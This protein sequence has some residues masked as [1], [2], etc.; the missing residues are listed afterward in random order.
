MSLIAQPDAGALRVL[1]TLRGAGHESYLCGG[2]VRDAL[3][4]RQPNDWDIATD[5]PPERVEALFPRTVAV[6][7]AFGVVVVVEEDVNYQ[8]ASFRADGKYVDGRRPETVRYSSAKEDAERRDFTINA[9]FYDPETDRV[10][11]Y[12]GGQEDLK[13]RVLRT[14]GD[15][16]RRFQEDHLRLL[17][18]V[19]FAAST[20]FDL[21]PATRDAVTE[22]ADR[23][24][25]V[26]AERIGAEITRMLVEGNARRSIELLVETGLS[27]VTLPEID[28]LAGV[29]QPE[30]FHPEGDVWVHTCIMLG[31]LDQAFRGGRV[32][33]GPGTEDYR[34]E[35]MAYAVLLHDIGKPETFTVSDRIRFN[36]HDTLG[37]AMGER[38]LERLKRP[39]RVIE[40]VENLIR[41]HMHFAALPHMRTAKRRRFLQEDLFELHLELHRIDC[42]GSHS[43]LTTY[44]FARQAL[45]EERARPP[46]PE[47]LLS[48]RDLI[49]LGSTLR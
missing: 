23:V 34:R 9:L 22:M 8:V 12:V 10:I 28:A 48:G 39:R 3:M 1:R 5:A 20:G 21:D 33:G 29:A 31:L 24:R 37:A 27:N 25:T 43:I 15:P 26:S 44:D 41:R 7:K 16:R 17:R 38:I 46:E 13:R 18:A 35:V 30:Q 40:A 47:P 45:E 14:V 19:R 42:A 32:P 2:S 4:G 6:G 49:A 36:G 11:D